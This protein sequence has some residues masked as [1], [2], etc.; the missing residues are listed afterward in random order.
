MMNSPPAP[1]PDRDYYLNGSSDFSWVIVLIA[2]SC[3]F[4]T[5]VA[6]LPLMSNAR[7]YQQVYRAQIKDRP[8]DDAI[9][10][11][12]IRHREPRTLTSTLMGDPSPSQSA[13]GR[14]LEPNE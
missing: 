10:N 4:A 5:I 2:W 13:L 12:V 6:L 7:K 8:S 3:L 1:P 14:K 9:H 11:A